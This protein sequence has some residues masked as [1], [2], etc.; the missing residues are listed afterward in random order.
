MPQEHCQAEGYDRPVYETIEDI[1]YTY[2][3][4]KFIVRCYLNGYYADGEGSK[5]KE[6]KKQAA[7]KLM[8]YMG[9]VVD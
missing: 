1:V 5:E 9:L 6:A 8:K 7:F 4:H 3:S 2:N